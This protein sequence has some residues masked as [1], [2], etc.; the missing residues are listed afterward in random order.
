MDAILLNEVFIMLKKLLPRH[1][2][3]I[4]HTRESISSVQCGL[5][6]TQGSK[7]V[8]WVAVSPVEG[9][10]EGKHFDMVSSVVL[11]DLLT[12]RW[13]QE[14]GAFLGGTVHLVDLHNYKNRTKIMVAIKEMERKT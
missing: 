1:I 5:L 13:S 6:N 2:Q 10:G 12:H 7:F 4:K 11:L 14:A 3:Y 9:T 8:V